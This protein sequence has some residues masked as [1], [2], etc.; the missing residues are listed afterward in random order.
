L[1]KCCEIRC[2]IRGEM[3]GNLGKLGEG[4]KRRS[5]STHAVFLM[6]S[7]LYESGP[8]Q[9]S[10]LPDSAT[11]AP[12]RV[13]ELAS[14]KGRGGA[15]V[16]SLRSA[17]GAYLGECDFSISFLHFLQAS[18]QAIQVYYGG[19]SSWKSKTFFRIFTSST[20]LSIDVGDEARIILQNG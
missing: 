9:F 8:I 2:G 4:L 13:V 5:T 15:N 7:G 16:S 1:K 10:R 12:L 3:G 18:V 6:F 11:L 14:R 17:W 19:L 20:T